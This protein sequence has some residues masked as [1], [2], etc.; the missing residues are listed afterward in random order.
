[1]EN[2]PFYRT[3]LKTNRNEI[4]DLVDRACIEQTVFEGVY[5]KL[6]KLGKDI[7]KIYD[8]LF[9]LEYSISEAP[10]FTKDKA[11]VDNMRKINKSIES[12]I[13]EIY[14]VLL[15]GTGRKIGE[16]GELYYVDCYAWHL[17]EK[18]GMM[19]KISKIEDD[20]YESQ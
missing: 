6:F 11:G 19:C 20:R 5:R 1:M 9:E 16:N 13:N 12:R 18:S 2:I 14:A 3:M 8:W 4:N 7:E 15:A 10:W 17:D